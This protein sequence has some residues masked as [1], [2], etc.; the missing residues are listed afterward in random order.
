MVHLPLR[1]QEW[2]YSPH[3]ISFPLYPMQNGCT[4]CK[5]SCF[6]VVVGALNWGLVGI[7][8]FVGTDWNVVHMLL[9]AW[10]KIEWLLYVLVGLSG[11]FK[12]FPQLCPTCGKKV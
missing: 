5:I 10:P 7:G 12:I 6:L 2:C 11:V 3:G 8:G 4:L 9:G 1:M